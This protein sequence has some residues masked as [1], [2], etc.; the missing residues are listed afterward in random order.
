MVTV[1]VDT[2]VLIAVSQR[3]DPLHQPA[4]AALRARASAQLVV[5]TVS[6][7]ELLVGAIRIGRAADAEAFVSRAA[8]LADVTPAIARRAAALRAD[9]TSLRLP[10]ALVI[11]TGL[12]LPADEILTADKRWVAVAPTVEVVEPA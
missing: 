5:S 7:A 10:D 8:V 11:A 3:T 2:S 9:R 12:E 4:L 6:Y 1:V